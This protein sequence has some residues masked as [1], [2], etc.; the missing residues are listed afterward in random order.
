MGIL[1]RPLGLAALTAVV[2]AAI[3][4]ARSWMEDRARA[5]HAAEQGHRAPV[6]VDTLGFLGSDLAES[7]GLAVSRRHPGVLWTHNDSGDGPRF[8][9]I[10]PTARFLGA[11]A[12]EGAEAVDWEDLDLGP[13]PGGASGSCLWLADTGDNQLR[14]DSV[15]VYVV[16]EPEPAAPTGSAAPAGRIR[17]TYPDG[18]HDVEALSVHPDGSLVMVTKGRTGRILLFLLSAP[19]IET[20]LRADAP[21]RPAPGR[22][23][24]ID[25]SWT[26][27]RVVTGASFD[28]AGATLAVRTYTEVFFLPWPLLAAWDA[29]P[30]SCFLG[31]LDEGGEAVAWED[32][33]TLLLTSERTPGR[34]GVLTRVR[35]ASVR[36]PTGE[37]AGAP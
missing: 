27:S 34:P 24:P 13:C 32:G 2:L 5:R 23:L 14:R 6:V 33:R 35:C 11:W 8:Y 1:R 26:L 37:G 4:L 10:D 21:A 19:E 12:V 36:G 20:A 25:P 17:I 29:A 18:P 28:P 16:A 31:R 3:L 30:P 7:S 9:A 22:E 15:V